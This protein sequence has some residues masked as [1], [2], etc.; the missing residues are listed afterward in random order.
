MPIYQCTLGFSINCKDLLPVIPDTYGFTAQW[1]CNHP[2]RGQ[3]KCSAKSAAR[4][5]KKV[6]RVHSLDMI[7]GFRP[8]ALV[9]VP[10]A[11]LV[12]CLEP[13]RKHELKILHNWAMFFTE[14]NIPWAIRQ[15]GK[16]LLMLSQ[17]HHPYET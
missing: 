7:A 6:F 2:Q 15:R 5:L 8:D 12:E 11:E 1:I 9:D 16:I 3:V 10:A 14:K 4:P 17:I 13:I